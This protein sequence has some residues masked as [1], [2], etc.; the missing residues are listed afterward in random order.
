MSYKDARSVD[1]RNHVKEDRYRA[2]S[3]EDGWTVVRLCNVVAHSNKGLDL[4][5]PRLDGRLTGH[6]EDLPTDTSPGGV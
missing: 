3:G 4:L 5:K 2:I 6:L 1:S